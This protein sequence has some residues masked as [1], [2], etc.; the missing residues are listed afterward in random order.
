MHFGDLPNMVSVMILCIAVV[1]TES[2]LNR[3]ATSLLL[4]VGCAEAKRDYQTD[5]GATHTCRTIVCRYAKPG[6]CSMGKYKDPR[7]NV[8]DWETPMMADD[9]PCGPECPPEDVCYE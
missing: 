7:T 8:V 2:P 3:H 1:V 4:Q 5:N 6:N 9:S